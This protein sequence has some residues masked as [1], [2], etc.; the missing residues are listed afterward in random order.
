MGTGS[1]PYARTD[2]ALRG[3]AELICRLH[4]AAAG[5]APVITSYRFDPRPP[6]PGEVISHSD[7]GPWNT[8]Y[9]DG[10]PVAFIDW[11]SPGPVDPLTDLAAAA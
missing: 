7:P 11:D 9:R 2:A 10:I 3:A 4:C 6:Q 8:V 5:F 1:P